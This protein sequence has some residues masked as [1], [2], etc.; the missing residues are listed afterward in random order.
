[1]NKKLIFINLNKFF[2]L[3]FLLQALKMDRDKREIDEIMQISLE[4][5]EM[6]KLLR[7]VEKESLE[8]LKIRMEEQARNAKKVAEFL[9]SHSK[10]EKIYYLGA[11]KEGTHE[12][13]IYKK[14]YSSAGAMISFDIKGGEK[15]AFRLLNELK[16]I[17]LAV[18][19][20]STESLAEHPATMT[21]A[22]V[23]DEHKK[24]MSISE[25][26]IRLSVGLENADDI[27]GDLKQALEKV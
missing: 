17:K 16:L 25:K 9:V 26:L 27:I 8:T 15:E 2:I 12:Y 21:H 24:G 18:S 13:E 7:E 20:G 5:Y 11:I 3:S 19:L 23:S 14:Q 4:T 1:M 22:G 10:V 6:E